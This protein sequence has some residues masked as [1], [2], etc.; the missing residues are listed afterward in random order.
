MR[1]ALFED[2]FSPRL[3]PLV[4]L[5]PVY[6]LKFGISSIR[7]KYE[8]IF[9]DEFIS[10]HCRPELV[11]V[12]AERYPKAEINT[13]SADKYVLI[14]GRCIIAETH[15]NK[16]I[17]DND[18]LYMNKGVVAAAVLSGDNLQKLRDAGS[19]LLSRKDFP[20]LIENEISCTWIDYPWDLFLKNGEEISREFAG[21]GINGEVY[22]GAN[23]INKENVLIEAGATVKPGVV[24]DA[25]KGPVI[26]SRAVQIMPNAYVQ[27]P[28]YIGENSLIKAGAKIYGGTSIGEQC[29]VGG[30]VGDSIIHSYTNKQHDGFLGHSYLGKW[31]NLGADTNNSDLKNNYGNVRFYVEGESIDT[32]SMFCGL[33]MGDHSKTGINSMIN[34][35]S[36]VGVA[37]NLFG[38][39]FPPKFVP[40]F[41]WGG[42]KGMEDHKLEKAIETA[43]RVMS[44]RDVTMTD[45]MAELF[46]T[47]FEK[48]ANER[49][50]VFSSL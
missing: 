21:A 4:H 20:D 41:S 17:T 23:I 2:E 25:E 18:S 43:Q 10:L 24:I 5:R 15:V 19:S 50:K 47:V 22:D 36:H 3:N 9:T 29:K 39:E 32:G 46:K 35:G 37:C 6:D 11:D 40:S 1:L 49:K 31:V 16:I 30:E 44:R 7:E 26:I 28:V 14:N 27:G 42:A 33:L 8:K 13:Y 34:T 48:T 12:L 38:S 45:S